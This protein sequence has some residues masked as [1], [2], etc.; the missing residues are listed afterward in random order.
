MN[1]TEWPWTSHTL[2]LM[3]FTSLLSRY[4]TEMENQTQLLWLTGGRVTQINK[5]TGPFLW[6]KL[7]TKNVPPLIGCKA[8]ILVALQP[9]MNTTF[10]SEMKDWKYSSLC[11]CMCVWSN[12]NH[13]LFQTDQILNMFAAS[14]YLIYEALS[15]L[16]DDNLCRRSSPPLWVHP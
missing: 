6:M 3:Y 11:V 7:L 8:Y 15:M 5:L 12:N 13:N 9:R 2:S 14:H 16:P 4:T 10:T 1:F